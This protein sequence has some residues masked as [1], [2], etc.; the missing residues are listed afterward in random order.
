MGM[1]SFVRTP[2]RPFKDRGEASSSTTLSPNTHVPTITMTD[3]EGSP[4]VPNDHFEV[5]D[6]EDEEYTQ[7]DSLAEASN[8]LCDCRMDSANRRLTGEH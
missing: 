8:R 2:R 1:Q 4:G 7:S 6:D 5:G 3:D